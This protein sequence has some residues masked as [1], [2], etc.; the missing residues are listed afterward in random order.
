ME[1]MVSKQVPPAA[2]TL[3]KQTGLSKSRW[4]RAWLGWGMLR[5]GGGQG[6]FC[7]Q[8]VKR[9]APALKAALSSLE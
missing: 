1:L 7:A 3:G 8:G 6:A 4:A 9:G 2:N 5:G